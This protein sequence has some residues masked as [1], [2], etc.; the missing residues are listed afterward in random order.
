M[1]ERL[2]GARL[3]RRRA[4]WFALHPLCVHCTIVGRVRLAVELDHVIALSNGGSDDDPA[5][6]QGLCRECHD[7]KTRADRGWGAARGCDV[8]GL[9]IDPTHPWN[10]LR[11]ARGIGGR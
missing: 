4:R 7:T 2:R 1:D 11:D 6:W 3:Q 10:V 8:D 9:P 5:N